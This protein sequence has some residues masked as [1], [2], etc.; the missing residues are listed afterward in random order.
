[1]KSPKTLCRGV[2]AVV[3]LLSATLAGLIVIVHTNI[4]WASPTASP[5]VRAAAKLKHHPPPTW[6]R[7][8]L[9]DDR[10][11]I[12]GG[13]WKVV[14]TQSDRLYHRPDCPLMLRRD[15]GATIGF[16]SGQD[17]RDSGY[18]ADPYCSPDLPMAS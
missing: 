14:S 5:S 12:A 2:A 7:H 13:I 6:I 4:S 10:Y 1:M 15:P 16:S 9:G 8:Y 11:K 3:T 18:E 17:A